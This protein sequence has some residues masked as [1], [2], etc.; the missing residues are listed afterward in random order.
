[1]IGTYT[2]VCFGLMIAAGIILPLG[3]AI[4][5]VK[6]RHEKFTTVLV[7]AATW[8]VFAIILESI[9]K[10][11]LFNQASP[12]GKAVLGNVFLFTVFGALL[13]GIF[14]ETGRLVAFKTVLKNRTNKETGISHGIGHGGF[15]A[16]YLLLVGGIQNLIYA[17]MVNNGTFGVMTN[18]GAISTAD[19]SALEAIPEALAA[20]TLGTILLSITERIFAMIFHVGL[21]IL[22]FSAVKKSRISLYFL[23]IAM[24]ALFDVPAALYQFGVLNLYVTE[25]F[26]AIFAVVF[27]FVV[28]K[29]LHF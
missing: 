15:E 19:A 16:M 5:W 4:W 11:F 25:I 20:I 3:T 13:A 10:A 24:H 12:I 18:R 17:T 29:K 9:P 22:V 7:G 1:M 8:F 6:T 23:A 27:T 2:F 26:I 28:Y 21:S 14:E